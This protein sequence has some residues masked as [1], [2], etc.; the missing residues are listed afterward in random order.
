MKR[1]LNIL[2]W[3][4]VMAYLIVVLGLVSDKVN[5]SPCQ[6]LHIEIMDSADNHFVS[7]ND[8]YNL[9][10]QDQTNILGGELGKINTKELEGKIRNTPF[11]KK[12]E[13]FKSSNGKL[14]VCVTQREPIIRVIDERGAGYYIDKEANIMPLGEYYT[15]RVMVANGWNLAGGVPGDNLIELKDD[16]EYRKIYELYQL[17]IFIYNDN[18]WRAQIEQIYLTQSGEFQLIPRVGAHIIEFGDISN[19]QGKFNKLYALYNQGFKNEG[20]NQYLKIDLK[21]ENQVVCT[22]R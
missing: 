1:I 14:N 12:T 3:F 6:S 20:W 8:I 17:G 4:G 13:V 21:Y 19:C 7:G 15:A 5:K 11:V 22:K 2:T 16:A 10:I 9:I 18:F